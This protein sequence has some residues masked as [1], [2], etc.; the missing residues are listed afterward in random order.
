MLTYQYYSSKNNQTIDVRHGMKERLSNWGEVCARAGIDPGKTPPDAAVERLIS[1]G[2][3]GSVS[4]GTQSS[5]S[6]N[7]LPMAGCCGNPSSCRHH[8]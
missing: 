7:A 8:G 1:G 5:A 6:F 4:G 3:L 2:L